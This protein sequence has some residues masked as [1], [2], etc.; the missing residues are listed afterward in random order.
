MRVVESADLGASINGVFAALTDVGYVEQFARDRGV[1][2][3]RLDG[4]NALA[5]GA[6]W[7]AR[8]A[9]RGRARTL[10]ARVED[11]E[12]PRRMV[13]AGASGGFEYRAVMTLAEI[14]EGATRLWSDIEVRPRSLSAR[15]ILQTVKLGRNR[16]R[17]RFAQRLGFLAR[18]IEERIAAGASGP[19]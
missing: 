15:I 14:P 5:V 2:L 6:E 10:T 9:F 11:L 18:A 8:F 16:L 12:A 1:V 4:G 13:M 3:K 19:T 17:A 7:Q